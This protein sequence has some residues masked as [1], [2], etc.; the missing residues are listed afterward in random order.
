MN[1]GMHSLLGEVFGTNATAT[2]HSPE[3]L[4]KQ[5]N[6]EFFGALCKE[7]GINVQ[8]LNDT[9]VSELYK[10]AM[11]L[12]K[13]A[14]EE[15][16]KPEEKKPEGKP[17]EKEK[18]AQAAKLAAAEAEFQEKRA[19]RVKV[20]EAEYMGRIMAHAMMDELNKIKT[21]MDG[22][23]PPFP[24]KKDE[25]KGE[26]K[27]PEGKEEGKEK[28]SAAERV[29]AVVAQPKTAAVQAPAATSS[30]PTFDEVAAYTAIDMLKEAGVDPEVA[31]A[32]VNAAYTLGLQES[33]KVASVDDVRAGLNIRA[34]EICE[35]AGFPVNW[36]EA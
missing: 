30:M 15:P 18:E 7:H 14:G 11:D 31:F 22:G 4:E 2:G 13:E 35:A 1:Q 21:A 32:R 8:S 5:A 6:F 28:K 33:T 9:Q 16:K 29:A 3:D 20:A 10:V 23:A 34:L 36:P 27:K 12:R 24:P 19:A 25:E 17:E 26:E